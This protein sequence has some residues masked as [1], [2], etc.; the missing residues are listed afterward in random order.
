MSA[1]AIVGM[2]CRFAGAPDLQSFWRLVRDGR[3]A[4]GPVPADRWDEA[5]FRADSAR[6]MDRTTAPA[7]A[8]LDDI[9]TFP[10]LALG[11]PPRRVE[12]MDPQQR[13]ALESA[14]EAIEDAGYAPGRLPR[15]T[16]VYVGITAHEY[17]LLHAARITA[18]M[19]A[20]GQFGV[21][22]EDAAAFA[23]AV[24][25]VV[26]PRP[27]S[28]P[29]VL[30]NMCAAIV[31]QELDLHGPAYTLDAA[32]ASAMVAVADAV[33]QLRAGHI[34]AALAGGAYLQINPEHYVAFTRIGAMSSSGRCLPFDARADGFV[35]GD[36]VGMV[37]LKR[38][39]D[40]V[41]DG[42]RVYA[43]L[44]G[45]AVNNDG[46]GDGPMAPVADGQTDVVRT[47]W[48]NAGLDP[49][50]AS[51]VETHGTGTTVGDAT[52]LAALR[53]LLAP[54][55]RVALGSSKANI[56]HTMSAAGIA[57]LIKAALSIHHATIPPLAGFEAAKPE[58]GLDDG[59]FW[60]PR[61]PTPWTDPERIAGVSSFGFGGTNGHAVMRAVPPSAAPRAQ[62]EL[63]LLSGPSEAGLRDL[64][65]RTAA[66]M[67]DDPSMTV[68]GV[69][70]AWA[71]RRRQAWRAGLVAT[72]RDTLL[73]GLR[74]LARGE[75]LPDGVVVG[76]APEGTPS[77]AFLYP[78]QGAQRVGMLRD[79][80]ARFD[81]VA[82]R[83]DQLEQA[84]DG[85]L[86]VP[87]TAL[88][89]PDRRTTPV[90][91][92]TAAADLT[93][94]EHCQPAMFA[95]GIALTDLL[96]R[97]GVQP[98]VVTGHS[99]GEFAAASA[100][101]IVSADDAA[102]FVARRGR[103]MAALPGEHGAM[104]AVMAEREV[105]DGLLVDGAVVAN[106][107]HPR[108]VV[109]SGTAEA[110]AAVVARAEQAG[111]RAR[112]LDVSHAFHS[113]LLA[114]LDSAALLAGV[115]L[116]DG[117]V[118]VASG[119]ADRAYTAADDAR[120]V[121]VRHATSPV[122]FTGALAQCL[123]VGA[124]LF[125]QVGAGG[126]L[127]SF[128]RGVVPEGVRGVF[129]LAPPD[130]A[131]GGR[132]LLATLAQ[133]WVAGV[134]IDVT[135]ITAPAPLASVP[136]S[137]LPRE[138]YWVVKDKRTRALHLPGATS[139]PARVQAEAA[140]AA[141]EAPPEPVGPGASGDDVLDGVLAVVAKVS[142]YPRATLKASMKLV[143]D[144]GFDSLMLGD[145]AT[146]LSE[147]FPGLP[148]IPQELLINGPSVDDL[149]TF[150]RTGAVAG[151]G[152]D[153]D[154]PLSAWQPVWVATPLPALPPRALPEGPW[155]VTGA[156]PD[157]VAAVAEGLRTAGVAVVEA[158]PADVTA[159]PCLVWVG[160]QGAPAPVDAARWPDEAG[161]LLDVVAR[162]AAA[163]H[164]PDVVALSRRDDPW[165]AGVAGALRALA[166]EWPE[167]RVQHL[168]TDDLVATVAALPAE[169][170]SADGSV[171]VRHVGGVRHT[172]ALAPIDTDGSATVG[173]DDTVLVTGG[174]RGIGLQLGARFAALGAR[175]I[176]VG[177]SAPTG[178]DAAIAAAF[179][180]LR[181]ALADVLDPDALVAAVDGAPVTVLVH[182]AGVLAD[183]AVEQVDAA[184]GRA[185]RRV[186]V[187]GWRHALAA[188]G[189]TLRRAVGIGSWAGRL[190]NRHQT[191]YAAANALLA[192]L[193]R[194][195]PDGVHAVVGEFGPWTGSA[196]VEAIP[197]PV[198]AAMRA[199]GVDFV[200]PQ[201]GLDALTA[202]LG[203]PAGPV[204]HG[205]TL[206]ATLRRTRVAVA[207]DTA[208][209]PYLNDHA[210]DGVP[211]LPLAAVADLL[212]WGADVP[213]PL[214][215]RDLTLYAGVTV[216]APRALVVA[217]DG[218]RA[219]LRDAAGRLHDTARVAA[220]APPSDL[221]PPA[222]GGQAPS[223]TLAAFYDGLTF[224]GP[225]LQGIVRIDAVGDGFVRGVVRAG[226]PSD[227]TPDTDRTTFTVDPLALDS[228]MQLAAFVAW[229]RYRRAGTPVSMG[230]IVAVGPLEPG[231]SYVA[232]AWFGEAVDDRFSA[233]IVIRDTEGAPVLVA[234]DV[235][236][237][238]RRA[239]VSDAA[240]GEDGTQAPSA[241]PAF[242]PTTVDVAHWP[243]VR[244]LDL[245]LE[246]VAALGLRNPYFHVHEG[247]ARNT[248]VVDGRELINFSSYNYIGLSG[249]P[250]VLDRVDAAVR[251]YGTSVSA[252]RVAS[253]ERP[254]HH[255]LEAGLAA[256]QGA[257]DALLFTA[258]HATNVTTVGH[259]MGPE[260]LILHD[261]YIHDS[262]LQGIKL[263]GA[264]RRGFRHDDPDHLEAQLTALRGGYRRCLIVVEGVYS[265]D[266]DICQLPRYVALKRRFG[267]L[268]M[269]DEAHSFGVV[270]ARGC[271][272]GEHWGIDGR[273]VD[274]WMGTLSKS[275][276]SC[277]GW[278]AGSSA[279]IRYLR[280][281]APGF[282]YSAGLTP[283]NGVAALASLELMLAE[284]ERVATLQ[285]NARTFH[286]ACQ[287]RGLDTGPSRGGS[288]V[289][290]VIT[291]NSMHALVLSE[292]L[293]DA[294][295]NVQPIVYP[296]VAD[297]AA[298]LRF[299][300]SSTHT[301]DQLRHT[302]NT[303]AD[304]LDRIRAELPLP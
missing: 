198:R 234:R 265:M 125:L 56:G 177:R 215:V 138:P 165:A 201:A 276:A 78:G 24:D 116:V 225:L 202:D 157:A 33:A 57:G 101:G 169:L 69:A 258:G 60:V 154:A 102:R 242:D 147:R 282:V 2:A 267:A 182:A 230:E 299:F 187:D 67:D 72:S 233:T 100:A 204:V 26:P 160:P 111:V 93:A 31:A 17:R 206:P 52:E 251:R 176:L 221:P 208:S 257:E 294:G 270:G 212:A 124:D 87:L 110:V 50:R 29:G 158:A 139:R 245:R 66:A 249:D 264:A 222:E 115:S 143:D 62:A 106:V 254:F 228:A 287:A 229:E 291:G 34:D 246:G 45:V 181:V 132:G 92:A 281:T 135:A 42:D 144:L 123:D 296:A 218:G 259:L 223:T 153:D 47:A 113:P 263:S 269:V 126:P 105:V 32:C 61:A 213:H 37:L 152:V 172:A 268:L 150:V 58:L 226:R 210:I 43:V 243:E 104:A 35:Q 8:F 303:V 244:D 261:A 238:L 237:E 168:T 195:A 27:F 85:E 23:D 68:A 174:T 235:V 199:D 103:A 81:V 99:L 239:D 186:K 148:G 1:I 74:A 46:R 301:A 255:A 94:T 98:A 79:L 22:P 271:G 209:D 121:F 277:G 3:D 140:P 272:V 96:A 166:R 95:A 9:R 167:A 134:D 200:G 248:T 231:R 161:D 51:H 295:I 300:L 178:D 250:R 170:A 18:M 183:G 49:A 298:R 191:H 44:E 128:A 286:D 75:P 12:V 91:E 274:V 175:V 88:L 266:G 39:D 80:A 20:A 141:E 114:G 292:R 189:P 112:A 207:L 97:V 86:T 193:A 184:T 236:A 260:D 127:A 137:V 15:G 130:D 63:V 10:A 180:H 240:A 136:P 4:F 30:G 192:E 5:M 185:A 232:E 280:Y 142:A 220:A 40:A 38:L 48:R 289:V 194:H 54:G 19:M 196:M 36:G 77:V 90:D 304:L 279:L 241:A 13:F 21:P 205:R 108:Q 256:A 131:D 119:I 163:G 41:R 28:A 82:D 197:A 70:R 247:T 164:R 190:G 262:I 14:L 285:A 118:P 171:D 53:P 219:S 129:T 65:A 297:D 6:D 117:Q 11:I 64:A 203:M 122:V 73:A 71:G 179:P 302:A 253:G 283:A 216:E 293:G 133:L 224:H 151:D 7:G 149:A 156:H 211:V 288:G 89:W 173:A 217:V 84:L 16:G 290:P 155:T 214:A 76:E 146:G 107:N 162:V 252:S 188:C 83:L 120:A 278:I 273:E 145:L 25:N 55:A 227:W 284:P 275:L 59:P 159:T 109:V